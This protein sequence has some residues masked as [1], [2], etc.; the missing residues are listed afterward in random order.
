MS[1]TECG[2]FF[3]V[4]GRR[5]WYWR[6]RLFGLPSSYSQARAEPGSII[7]RQST[8]AFRRIPFLGF[9]LAQFAPGNMVPYFPM[10]LYLAVTCPVSGCCMWFMELDSS[11][12]YALTRGQCL[13]RQWIHVL[14]QCLVLDE[15]TH[16]FYVEVD[17]NP[18]A[19]SLRSHAKWRSVLRRCFSFQSQKRCKFPS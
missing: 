7:M 15:F 13:A 8:M 18:V 19:F 16:S 12:D 17:S 3:L 5:A 11:G 10:A 9:W 6:V 4:A 2:C 14:H 1:D